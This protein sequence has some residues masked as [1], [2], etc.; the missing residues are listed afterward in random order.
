MKGSRKSKN[1]QKKSDVSLV[2]DTVRKKFLISI[3]QRP[4]YNRV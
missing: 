4:D 2:I 3:R 1:I